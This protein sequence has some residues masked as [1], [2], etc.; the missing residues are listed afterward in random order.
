[1]FFT[2]KVLTI[3][4]LKNTLGIN[5]YPKLWVIVSSARCSDFDNNDQSRFDI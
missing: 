3:Q 5:K 2:K 1:M 4:Y